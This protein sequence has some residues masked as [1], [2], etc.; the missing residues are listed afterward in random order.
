MEEAGRP[1]SL[2]GPKQRALLIVLLLHRGEPLSADRLIDALWGE[3]PPATAVKAL[4]GYV[5]GLRK[6]LGAG[7]I[8][9]RGGG[10]LLDAGSEQVDLER[11]ERLARAGERAL[12][13]GEPAGASRRLEEALRLWRGAPLSDFRY[14]SFAQ[15]EIRRLEELHLTTLENRIEADLQLGRH[16]AVIAELER[17]A[18]QHP[19]RERLHCQLMLALYRSGRQR[20]ALEHYRRARRAM[21]DEL[22]IEPGPELHRLEGAIL[23][24]DPK[25]DAPSQRTVIERVVAR[26]DFGGGA[27]VAAGGLLLLAVAVSAALLSSAGGSGPDI[28]PNSVAVIDGASDELVD[29]VP[30]GSRPADISSDGRSIWVANT[31]DATASRIDPRTRTVLRTTA[32]GGS[33]DGL[34]SGPSGVWANDFHRM[35]M[36]RLNPD[37]RGEIAR[38]RI[39][40]PV[41]S[42]PSSAPVAVG[43]RAVWAGNG[44]SSVMKI[45]P[46]T[47]RLQARIDVGNDPASIAVGPSGVWVADDVDDT[48]TR[49][50]PRSENAVTDTLP[51]GRAPSSIAVGEGAVWVANS[52]DDNVTRI[53]ADTGSVTATIQVGSRPTGVATGGGAVWVANNLD[54]TVSRIDPATN[55]VTDEIDVGEAPESLVVASG[56]VW[57]SVQANPEIP[58]SSGGSDSTIKVLRT[59]DTGG[60]DPSQYEGPPELAYATCAQLYNYPD[61]ADA[62]GDKLVPEVA[63]GPPHVSDGGLIHTYPIRSGF[64]FSPPSNQPVTAA[65]FA[66]SIQRALDPRTHSYAAGIMRDVTGVKAHGNRLVVRLDQPSSDLTTRLATP[67]FCAVPADTPAVAQTESPIPN[68]GPY[69]IASY[70]PRKSLV[71]KRNPNYG[72]DRPRRLAEIDYEFGGSAQSAVARVEAGDAD[73]YDSEFGDVSAALP[74]ASQA[75]LAAR[76]G[77]DSDMARAGHQ[78]YFVEPGLSTVALMFNTTRPPFDDVRLRRAVNFAIDRRALARLAFAF[79]QGRPT[80][81]YLPPGMPGFRDAAIYPLGGPNLSRARS[82]AGH[83]HESAVLYTCNLPACAQMAQILTSNLGRIGITLETRRFPYSRFF[84][85]MQRPGEHFDLAPWGWAADFPDPSN[86]INLQFESDEELVP[87]FHDPNLDARMR[88]AARLSGASRLDAYARLDRDLAARAAPAAAY[89]S[90]TSIKLFSSR[91]GCQLDQPIFGMDLGALCIRG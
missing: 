86:F 5:S 72:G 1:I 2:G 41:P 55:R 52:E 50:D 35:L 25:L 62:E 90:G 80:D 53:D 73:Y 34:G 9:T 67:W 58:T 75:R 48:V 38:V 79:A 85:L 7:A 87:T 43:P 46:V 6:A 44:E 32:P 40:R 22:G 54:G 70:E 91:V 12:E 71:L 10:Y 16:T 33:L 36:T 76:Y 63:A 78:Q 14:E 59:E 17:L 24:Q 77:P 65:S 37:F 82:L 84:D 45:D 61:R 15:S 42:L 3:R 68:A 26:S 57:V 89:A 23:A 81:Q 8:E 21:L 11:F 18:G 13:G 60:V 51:V 56:E 31:G 64:R 30:V 4:Q 29:D 49:I 74:S 27:L 47:N 69:Y 28:D 88:A 39:G 20:D 19:E 66:R 83:R